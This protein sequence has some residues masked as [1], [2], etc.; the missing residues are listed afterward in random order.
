MYVR[1]PSLAAAALGV[2]LLSAC[3]DST[4]ASGDS[5]VRF[6]L[7][8]SAAPAVT[9]SAS[10]ALAVEPVT[11][12]D[13]TNT[14]VVDQV[15]VVLREIELER[16]GE[17]D[18]ALPDDDSCEKL[19]LG[20]ILLDL[21]LAPGA[22]GQFTVPVD[23]GHYDEVE[24]E[25]HKASSS[26]DAAFVAAHPEFEDRS[27]RVS[28]SFNGAPFVFYSQLDLE[29]EIDLS[30]P[31]VVGESASAE[32]TLFTDLDG[33]FRTGAGELI[34]PA[35]A[36]EGGENESEVEA[37]IEGAFEAFEDSDRDGAED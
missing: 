35:T 15:Q 26:D 28:G 32:L 21:P 13:G 19:E 22:V 18:C 34:D 27:I 25:I 33:W 16:T 5:Q 23:T 17:D 2:A 31:L 7:A 9:A 24:L 3:S 20:P 11:F 12:T 6:N 4:G 1:H 14:L 8:T 36:N 29:Q 10:V 37:N 30:P